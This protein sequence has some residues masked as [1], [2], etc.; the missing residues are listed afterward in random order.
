MNKAIQVMAHI[1]F[2][3][4]FIMDSKCPSQNNGIL[5]SVYASDFSQIGFLISTISLPDW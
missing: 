5:Q 3:Y 1:V 4:Q 2:L